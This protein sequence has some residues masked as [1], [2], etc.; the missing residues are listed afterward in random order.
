MLYTT[1]YYVL[2]EK[3]SRGIHKNELQAFICPNGSYVRGK[4]P[5]SGKGILCSERA[6][7]IGKIYTTILGLESLCY[8]FKYIGADMVLCETPIKPPYQAVF[9]IRG[10]YGKNNEYDREK[11]CRKNQCGNGKV[12]GLFLRTKHYQSLEKVICCK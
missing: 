7:K 8:G 5:Y 3:F 4:L 6:P 10:Y 11:T 1:H 9:C 12:C 2:D